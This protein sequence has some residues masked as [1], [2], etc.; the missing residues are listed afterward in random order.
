MRTRVF[1]PASLAIALLTITSLVLAACGPAA[2]PVPPTQAPAPTVAPTKPP[3]P[4]KAPEPTK[5][6]TPVPPTA[7][8]A[9]KTQ[10]DII[11]ARGVMKVSTDP[12]YKPQSF[13]NETTKE[14]DGFDIE[15]AKEVAK[16]LGVKVEFITPDWDIIVAANWGGRWDV[17]IGSMT[18]TPERKKV[19]FFSSP[20]YYTPAQ[21][22]VPKNSTLTKIEDLAGKIVC[23]GSGTTYEEYLG[24]KLVLEGEPILKQVTGAKTQTFSTDSECIQAIQAGRKEIAAVLTALPT[25]EDAI[26]NGAPIKILGDPVYYEDLAAA[27][28]KNVPNSEPFVEAVTKAIDEM[29]KDGTLTKLAVK[30]YGVDISTKKQ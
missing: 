13:I 12:N 1:G 20:Y 19:L 17:S 6:P 18:I 7:T 14:L 26:K 23:V 4:T 5:P 30:W 27:F 2:T 29:R 15:V 11:K 9:P 28:D 16:R 25:I 22:A 10:L 3:E 21:F 24:G 8:P